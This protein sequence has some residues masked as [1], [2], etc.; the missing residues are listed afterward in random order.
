M[1]MFGW[2]NEL[3]CH[4][5]VR[6]PISENDS[7]DLD[8]IFSSRDPYYKLAVKIASEPEPTIP[9]PSSIIRQ[10]EPVAVVKKQ[11]RPRKVAA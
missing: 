9:E 6:S 11:G 8:D 10:E 7:K 3:N 2:S 1:H 4:V 5:W